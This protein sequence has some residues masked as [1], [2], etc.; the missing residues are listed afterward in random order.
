[1]NELLEILAQF[2]GGKGGEPGNV[3]VRFL[4]P[5]FFWSILAGVA[6]REWLR[7]RESKDLWV[8]IAS[9]TGMSR[10]LLMFAAEYGA[11]RQMVPFDFMYNYYPP[12]EHAATMISGLLIGYAF[13][14]YQLHFPSFSRPF[15]AGSLFTTIVLYWLTAAHWPGFLAHH[16][17]VSFGRFWG[18]MAFRSAA[19]LFMLLVLGAFISAAAQGKNVSKTLLCGFL[20]LFFDEFLMI[21]NIISDERHVDIYAPIRH[22]LHIWSIPFFLGTYWGNLSR[23][24]GT[25]E[26]VIKN[27]FNLSPGML[28]LISFEGTFLLA[29][30][31]SSHVLGIPSDEL[32]GRRLT[33]F[34]FETRRDGNLSFI[35]E[36][37]KVSP[38]CF[39][40]KYMPS[41]GPERWL[42]WHLQP[43][44]DEKILYAMVADVTEQKMVA[45]ELLDE[46]NKLEAILSC[47]GDGLSIRDTDH[48]I[49]YQNHIHKKLYGDHIGEYCY[50]V[51]EGQSQV[52]S[53]CPV[54]MAIQDLQVH[55]AVRTVEQ[56]G[57]KKHVEI[58]ASPLKDG[59]GAVVGA[60][61]AVRDISAR[62]EAEEEILRL[63][64]ELEQRVAERTERL[65]E[66]CREL[67]SFSYS[68]S[69]DLRSPLR[70]I[71]GYSQLLLE[72]CS[73]HLDDQGRKYVEVIANGGRRM[74]QIIDAMLDFSRIGRR[75]L[76]HED[77]DLSELAIVV[78]A[79]LHITCPERNVSF[80]IDNGMVVKG[81]PS[82]LR[83]VMENLFGN[84]WKYTSK[85]PDTRIEFSS[86]VENGSTVFLIRDN[87][88]GFNMA[89]ADK[90]FAPF[91][92][93][94][95][96]HEFPGNG[97]GLATVQR[98]IQRHGG[99]IWAESSPGDGASFYFTL[100]CYNGAV[101]G[102]E[103]PLLS[104][105]EA[106]LDP[107]LSVRSPLEVPSI[108]GIQ[109]DSAPGRPLTSAWGE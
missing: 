55:S 59:S 3:T 94:H 51:Y 98:I 77:V 101:P 65:A 84:A 74:E 36:D 12:L 61:E 57:F 40:K 47:L 44:S 92:R 43:D 89:H 67:E 72:D 93:L 63:N 108:D 96:E 25:A 9:T 105:G 73:E 103:S 85:E 29:S 16:P 64:A 7:T 13:L 35:P 8:A 76:R 97:I 28:G 50:R 107:R 45:E 81:D 70:T 19:A 27:V 75:E 23:R 48:R 78:T 26:Q 79:E 2:G 21:F 46:R 1:M 41:H 88:A 104:A 60:I 32:K 109:A 17:G 95:S 68:V 56:N 52:C 4:L 49:A 102:E 80:I 14:N 91:Q 54:A 31:A 38:I 66:A 15:L 86:R 53:S 18:D 83:S 82:L 99:R 39:E 58:T 6:F 87:G 100:G 22:N 34:G 33:D 10:E 62:K 42:Q 11:W 30:P 20:F 90:L 24:M 71:Y 5:T 69:H 106:S 37:G